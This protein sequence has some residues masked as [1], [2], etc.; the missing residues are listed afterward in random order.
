MITNFFSKWIERRNS[1]QERNRNLIE[2][3]G[4]E[5]FVT[6]VQKSKSQ[7][8]NQRIKK[9]LKKSIKKERIHLI[10]LKII[11]SI[12]LL[13]FRP[14]MQKLQVLKYNNF[15][16]SRKEWIKLLHTQIIN[17][18]LQNLKHS[19]TLKIFHKKLPLTLG[20]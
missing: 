3:R 14:K 12:E 17:L 4:S 7:G 20:M 8:L 1:L 10:G 13:L 11:V 5:L 2:K 19:K 16:N 15:Y 6:W 18:A 9:K